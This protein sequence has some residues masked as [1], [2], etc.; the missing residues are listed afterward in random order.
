MPVTKEWNSARAGRKEGRKSEF[1]APIA[2]I[3]MLFGFY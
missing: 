1:T 2:H 3:S